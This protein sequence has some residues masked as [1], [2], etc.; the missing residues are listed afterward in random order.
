MVAPSDTL[1][2]RAI[3]RP[4]YRRDDIKIEIRGDDHSKE[5]S[6]SHAKDDSGDHSSD[7]DDSPSPSKTKFPPDARQT[8]PPS[9]QQP[10]PVLNPADPT[11]SVSSTQSST[12]PQQ[13]APPASGPQRGQPP[14]SF[15]SVTTSAPGPTAVPQT[16]T[17][18]G[19][20]QTGGASRGGGEAGLGRDRTTEVGWTPTAIA[21]GTIAIAALCLVIGVSIWWCLRF[22]KRRKARRMFERGQP[23]PPPP[24]DGVYWDPA[25]TFSAPSAPV[26]RAP[27]SVMAE[28]MGH[29]YATENGGYYGNPGGGPDRNS[30]TPQGYLDE[31]RFDPARQLPVLEPA[32]VAQPNVRNSIASWI[33]RHHPLKLNPMSGRTSVYSARSAGPSSRSVNATAAPPVPAV[34]AVYR[35]TD[36]V[37]SPGPGGDPNNPRY[38]SS[39]RYDTDNQ[40][41]RDDT[42]SI[43]S[44]YENRPPQDSGQPGPWLVEPPAPLFAGRGVSMAPTEVTDRTESTWRTWGAGVS[45][46]QHQAQAAAAAAAAAAEAP[47]PGWIERCIKF[48][49]LK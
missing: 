2:R 1:R 24:P 34:P 16:T 13:S 22:H 40:S 20:Q 23:P 46:P 9:Q 43:L 44:L 31:K 42:N 15:T 18:S 33:R 39:S 45:Q 19:A 21:F 36:R 8:Q 25:V 11:E 4:R 47:R 17:S 29:A 49:G 14:A 37:D 48:G 35:S 3:R 7:E 27:S 6:K 32:P 28:L 30:L 38:A 26:R 41:A 12:L 10:P 5:H